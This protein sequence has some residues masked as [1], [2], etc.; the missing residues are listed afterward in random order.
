MGSASGYLVICSESHSMQHCCYMLLHVQSVSA[1]V[2]KAVVSSSNFAMLRSQ[3]QNLEEL[4]GTALQGL[5]DAVPWFGM[6][7]GDEV[8]KWDMRVLEAQQA[9]SV[10][11][12]WMSPLKT[13]FNR[14]NLLSSTGGSGHACLL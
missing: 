14:L 5:V 3:L 9:S 13:V 2:Q 10:A 8:C 6:V 11:G 7:A 1:G 4:V 12:S